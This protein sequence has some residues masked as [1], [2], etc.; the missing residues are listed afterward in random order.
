MRGDEA[1]LRAGV[2]I[3]EAGAVNGGHG[4]TLKTYTENQRSREAEQYYP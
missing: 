4:N 3:V 2:G 1:L